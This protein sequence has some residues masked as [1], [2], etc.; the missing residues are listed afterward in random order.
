[1]VDIDGKKEYSIVL[2]TRIDGVVGSTRLLNNP[3]REN[4]VAILPVDGNVKTEWRIINTGGQVINRGTTTSSRLE[5]SSISLKPG[6]Y[7]LQTISG[8]KKETVEF[9]KL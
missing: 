6:S 5:I 9:I 8:N 3:V 1:M 7:W 2:S 4:L